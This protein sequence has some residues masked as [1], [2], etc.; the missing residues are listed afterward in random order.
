MVTTSVRC[1]F[2]LNKIIIVIAFN[3]SLSSQFHVALFVSWD[4]FCCAALVYMEKYCKVQT[5]VFFCLHARYLLVVPYHLIN[6]Y[7]I[8]FIS[9]MTTSRYSRYF[10]SI[11]FCFAVFFFSCSSLRVSAIWLHS[12]SKTKKKEATR[13]GQQIKSPKRHGMKL[14]APTNTNR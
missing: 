9:H 8:H 3:L 13:S 2:F 11:R 7:S 5:F 1:H 14:T 10:L 4:V 12:K 6:L